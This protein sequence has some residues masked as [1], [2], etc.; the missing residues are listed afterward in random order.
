MTYSGVLYTQKTERRWDEE[1]QAVIRDTLHGAYYGH[2]IR[3]SISAG[4]NPQ[5]YG[6]FLFTNPNSRVQAIRHVIKP[7][8]GFSYIPV[9]AGLSSDMYRTAQIDDL[10]NTQEYSVFEGNIYGTPSLTKRSGSISLGLINIVEGKVFAKDDTTGVAQKVK[11]IDNL[12]VSTSYNIFADSMHWSPVS[13]TLRTVILKNINISANSNFSL[14]A[15]DENGKM[16]DTFAF[17]Y[18]GKLLRLTSFTTGF[19]FSL[20]EL[21]KGNKDK[22]VTRNTSGNT[23]QGIGFDERR[24]G[25]SNT[26]TDSRTENLDEYG[27]PVFDVPWTLNLNYSLNYSKPGLKSNI[28]QTLSLNGNAS[29]TRKMAVTYTSGYDFKNKEIT[30]TRIGISRDLHCWEMDFNWIPNG[31]MQGW[32]FTLRVKA[33][34]LG[35]LKYERRKDYHDRY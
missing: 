2:A 24:P 7:S 20:S 33:S 6:T 10:G 27:Y 1:S 8:I 12:G 13:V 16:F 25:Q 31:T 29:L 15:I 34:V 11:I 35:D 22:Q 19:N 26:R 14:Y 18:N 28:S 32:N 17:A 5:V 3:P 30:M 9:L 21:L 4:F 23:D